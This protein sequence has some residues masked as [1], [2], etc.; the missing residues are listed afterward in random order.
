M[1]NVCE[2][3]KVNIKRD[4]DVEQTSNQYKSIITPPPLNLPKFQFP[5][6]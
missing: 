5:G 2:Q 3:S 6:N 1:H 4:T